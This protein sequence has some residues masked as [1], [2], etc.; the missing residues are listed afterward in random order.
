MSSIRNV[1]VTSKMTLHFSR[2]FFDNIYVMELKVSANTVNMTLI[3]KKR[4]YHAP[5]IFIR[6]STIFG[7]SLKIFLNTFLSKRHIYFFVF[8]RSFHSRWWGSYFKLFPNLLL[9]YIAFL[10]SLLIKGAWFPL[11]NLFSKMHDVRQS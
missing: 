7:N 8:C 2:C 6:N 1:I 11:K 9:V 4:F 5:K 3:C 10:S